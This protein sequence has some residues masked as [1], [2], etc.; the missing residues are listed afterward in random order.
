MQLSSRTLAADT[1]KSGGPA[2]SSAPAS[3]ARSTVQA[4][5]ETDTPAANQAKHHGRPKA[6][7]YDRQLDKREP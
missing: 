7:R 1:R 3:N 5:A 2:R 4:A 6:L